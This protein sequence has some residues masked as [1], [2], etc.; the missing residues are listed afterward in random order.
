MLHLTIL[1]PEAL[2]T[3]KQTK[4]HKK[5][6]FWSYLQLKR[7]LHRIRNN[8][9]CKESCKVSLKDNFLRSSLS[10]NFRFLFWYEAFINEMLITYLS[11]KYMGPGKT[12]KWQVPLKHNHSS[13]IE[14]YCGISS[15]FGKGNFKNQCSCCSWD[16]CC[17]QCNLHALIFF[18]YTD[19]VALL[20]KAVE[21]SY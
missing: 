16:Y 10:N 18:A 17:H 7:A 19:K 9:G 2:K 6:S 13:I 14:I 12:L 11:L 1:P 4:N 21:L 8:T 5:T 20:S 3:N 15:C